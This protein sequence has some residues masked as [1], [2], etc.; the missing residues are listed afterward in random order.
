MVNY[1]NFVIIY[2]DS[3]DQLVMYFI[4]IDTTF[5]SFLKALSRQ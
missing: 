4:K 5:I 2:I 1:L 3:N